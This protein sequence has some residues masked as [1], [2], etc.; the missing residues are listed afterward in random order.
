MAA[1]LFEYGL[2][3]A[4]V[5]TVL[6]AVVVVIGVVAAQR[7]DKRPGDGQVEVRKLNEVLDD[8]RFALREH[9]IDPDQLKREEKN[10]KAREKRERTTLRTLE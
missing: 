2:F 5:L 10:R 9:L 6:I 4:K 7:Q 1:F 8:L 3:L